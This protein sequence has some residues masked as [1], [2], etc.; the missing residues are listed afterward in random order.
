[1]QPTRPFEEILTALAEQDDELDGLLAG[2]DE[3]GWARP[4]RCPGWSVSDVVLHLAQTDEMAVASAERRFS[5]TAAAFNNPGPVP[6]GATVDDLAG[7]AV[8]ADRGRPAQEVY[9][10]WRAAS[11]AQA[12]AFAACE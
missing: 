1:M 10:R 4:S 7:L 12:K 5:E 3:E 6:A 2:L 11:A 8:E 9:E